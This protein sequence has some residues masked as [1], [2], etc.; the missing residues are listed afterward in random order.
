MTPKQKPKKNFKIELHQNF[1]FCASK[2]STRNGKPTDNM[3]DYIKSF[4]K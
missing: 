3:G 4:Y 1:R 2:H